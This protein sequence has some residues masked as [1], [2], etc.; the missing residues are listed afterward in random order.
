MTSSSASLKPLFSVLPKLTGFTGHTYTLDDW[1]RF[2]QTPLE[3]TYSNLKK[4]NLA[5]TSSVNEWFSQVAKKTPFAGFVYEERNPSDSLSPGTFSISYIPPPTSTATRD[6]PCIV[7]RYSLATNSTT[8]SPYVVLT[9]YILS[10]KSELKSSIRTYI[11]SWI[12][13][14]QKIEVGS[15]KWRQKHIDMCEYV[16]N[17]FG[18]SICFIVPTQDPTEKSPILLYLPKDSSFEDIRSKGIHCLHVS[19]ASDLYEWFPTWIIHLSKPAKPSL[20]TTWKDDSC[21]D[22]FVQRLFVSRNTSFVSSNLE[23]PT[24]IERRTDDVL[25]PLPIIQTV[26]KGHTAELLLGTSGNVYLNEEGYPLVGWTASTSSLSER[27]SLKP[28][29]T[30]EISIYWADTPT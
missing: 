2:I 26:Y 7:L 21:L 13:S 8:M 5:W 30:F 11:E 25:H 15:E 19:H 23:I 18:Q 3:A 17:Q 24:M 14:V 10:A 29:D 20:H 9:Q 28:G 27:T 6:K 12:S 16:W 1:N 4:R 22:S